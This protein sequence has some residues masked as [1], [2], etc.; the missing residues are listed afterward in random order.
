MFS[1]KEL[2]DKT[3]NKSFNHEDLV[4]SWDDIESFN[5]AG[6][7]LPNISHPEHDS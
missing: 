1:A 3:R 4:L 5:D 6:F 2:S 7:Y